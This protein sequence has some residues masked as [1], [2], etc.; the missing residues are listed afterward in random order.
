MAWVN[1]PFLLHQTIA[2]ALILDDRLDSGL[3]EPR[4]R[5]WSG[6]ILLLDP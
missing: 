2:T 6:D 5:P 3:M 1:Y 4:S